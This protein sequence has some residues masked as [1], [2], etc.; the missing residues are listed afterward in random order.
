MCVRLWVKWEDRIKD[1]FGSI[2]LERLCGHPFLDVKVSGAQRK[3][4]GYREPVGR[5]Q[6]LYGI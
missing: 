5:Q 1:L 4:R 6:P 3:S 2:P